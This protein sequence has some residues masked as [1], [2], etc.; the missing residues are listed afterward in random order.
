MNPKCLIIKKKLRSFNK[1][2]NVEGD[3]SLSIRWLLLSSQAIGVSRATNLLK[4]EDVYS[5][6][7]CLKKL[8]V[9]I[10]FFKNNCYLEGLGIN[11]FK[12]KKN[13]VLDAGNSGTVGRL[14][15]PLL[16]KSPYKIKI[17][18]DKS[19]SKRDFSRVTEPLSRIGVKFFP[20]KKKIFQF[21]YLALIT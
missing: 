21:S 13:L 8:G 2:I 12:F 18:G 17:I 9:N 16:I 7:K 3:K 15:L 20:S 14:I 19:L 10:K 5:A 1:K 11:G 6:I 4:S